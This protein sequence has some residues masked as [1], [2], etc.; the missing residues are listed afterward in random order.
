MILTESLTLSSYCSF[1]LKRLFLYNSFGQSL[2]QEVVGNDELQENMVY[3]GCSKSNSALNQSTQICRHS[4][5]TPLH[6]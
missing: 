4:I 6:I 1:F 2:S 3:I 5:T